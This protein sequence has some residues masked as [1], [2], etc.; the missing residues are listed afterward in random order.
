MLYKSVS[1]L[2][3]SPEQL[4]R[5]LTW[6]LLTY[7]LVLVSDLICAFVSQADLS[8]FCHRVLE[9]EVRI[10]SDPVLLS[11]LH[12]LKHSVI[13]AVLR[14]TEAIIRDAMISH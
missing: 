14:R 6:L 1:H 2:Y 12:N 5:E 11:L 7:A 10:P 4:N 8:P 9:L 3:L 13:P